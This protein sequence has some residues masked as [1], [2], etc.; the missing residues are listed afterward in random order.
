MHVDHPQAVP[1]RL[2]LLTRT[3]G[4]PV[5]EY[6]ALLRSQEMAGLLSILSMDDSVAMVVCHHAGLARIL[7]VPFVAK[8]L[9]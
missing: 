3:S 5:T 7:E 2:S 6:Q 8:V 4:R 1:L 9:S